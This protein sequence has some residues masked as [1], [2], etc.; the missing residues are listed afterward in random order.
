MPMPEQQLQN[1]GHSSGF[2]R[3]HTHQQC[4]Q[5]NPKVEKTHLNTHV[6]V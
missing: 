6:C 3:Q 4:H 5:L 1:Q 2:L